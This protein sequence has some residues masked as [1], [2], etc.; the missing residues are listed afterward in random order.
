VISD[1]SSAKGGL[2][3]MGDYGRNEEALDPRPH[4]LGPLQVEFVVDMWFQMVDRSR[5]ARD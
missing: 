3:L 4:G 2:G 1:G 5:V